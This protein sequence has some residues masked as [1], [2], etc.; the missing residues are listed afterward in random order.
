MTPEQQRR[1]LEAADRLTAHM[2]AMHIA[3]QVA[4]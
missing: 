2:S 1:L 3:G 4:P